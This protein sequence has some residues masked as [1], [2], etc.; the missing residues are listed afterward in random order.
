[1]SSSDL[2]EVRR[3][4]ASEPQGFNCVLSA[5]FEIGWR[6]NF[7]NTDLLVAALEYAEL[8]WGAFRRERFLG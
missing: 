8:P 7:L 5:D 6:L 3:A 4:K 2:Q 1:M